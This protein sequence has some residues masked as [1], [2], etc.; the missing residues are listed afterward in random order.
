MTISA[1]VDIGQGSNLNAASPQVVTIT[2]GI[3]V[4]DT[5]VVSHYCAGSGIPLSGVTDSGGINVYKKW[6]DLH[7][8]SPQFDL[9]ICGD[10]QAMATGTVSASY[11]TTSRHCVNVMRIPQGLLAAFPFDPHTGQSE[12][13]TATSSPNTPVNNYYCQNQLILGFFILGGGTSGGTNPGTFAPGAGFTALNSTP[14]AQAT[15]FTQYQ[16]VSA[17]AYTANIQNAGSWTASLLHRGAS[18]GLIGA[19][20]C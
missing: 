3:Q 16:I 1:P 9:W 4:H 15:I 20:S 17:S 18:V 19:C 5:I 12:T 7:A 11:G 6:V 10:A 8:S 13:S 14:S 2:S